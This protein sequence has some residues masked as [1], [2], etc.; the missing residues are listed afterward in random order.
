MSVTQISSP[1]K[2]EV[3]IKKHKEKSVA[4]SRVT[5][6]KAEEEDSHKTIYWWCILSSIALINI[7][8]WCYTYQSLKTA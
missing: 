3:K 5:E 2:D 1:T 6:M 7:L 8:L 4:I